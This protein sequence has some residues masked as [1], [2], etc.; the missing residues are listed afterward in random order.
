M[1]TIKNIVKVFNRHF[2]TASIGARFE[3]EAGYER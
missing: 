2:R 1:N 3:I